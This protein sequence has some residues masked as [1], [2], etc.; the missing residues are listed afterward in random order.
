MQRRVSPR[1]RPA[2]TRSRAPCR[3]MACRQAPC[4]SQHLRSGLLA[5]EAALRRQIATP[6][7]QT[8]GPRHPAMLSALAE[9]DALT[10]AIKSETERLRERQ[11]PL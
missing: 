4:R 10:K 6:E 7:A 9:I 1:R 3:S 5:D 11:R 8:L 2:T